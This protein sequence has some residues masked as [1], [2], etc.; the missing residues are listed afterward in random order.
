MEMRQRNQTG[1]KA[2][3]RTATAPGLQPR[4]FTL[5]EL[6]IAIVVIAI[7][8]AFLLPAIQGIT[9]TAKDSA[10]RNEISQLESAIAT[11]KA[12]YGIEP[13]SAIKI[14]EG[15][16]D[17]M[18][19]GGGI[20]P[21]WAIDTTPEE[22]ANPLRAKS[23]TLIQRMWPNYNFSIDQDL[24]DDGDS[25]DVYIL[26][27]STTLI[28]LLGGVVTN[29]GTAGL[30]GTPQGFSKNPET[31]FKFAT[32]GELREGPYF[33]FQ[34]SRLRKAPEITQATDKFQILQYFDP[35][36]TTTNLY[37]YLSSYD[38]NGYVAKDIPDDIPI[39]TAYVTASGAGAAFHKPKSF[40]IISAGADGI[41]GDNK[42]TTDPKGSV[43]YN[44]SESNNGLKT[45]TGAYDN[46]T[47]F[48]P[49]RLKP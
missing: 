7:L 16:E 47:N 41:Y 42:L 13:P 28:F 6:M 43:V 4:G 1:R 37:L 21:N 23:R 3:R 25:E 27:A 31:P 11:F 15:R 26:D 2:T 29:N 45:N 10:V 32:A 34:P 20:P 49:G 39:G 14:Y 17:A 33:E 30:V 8:A 12:K 40:Q 19:M 35:L 46:I 9:G 36:G 22:M 44:T 48:A 5:L 38:G 18:A 24:N